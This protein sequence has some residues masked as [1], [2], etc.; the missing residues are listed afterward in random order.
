MSM[1]TSKHVYPQG[2]DSLNNLVKDLISEVGGAPVIPSRLTGNLW[3]IF[4]QMLTAASHAASHFLWIWWCL[5]L[6][7]RSS[8]LLPDVTN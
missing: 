8:A 4:T 2:L 7:Q 6:A 1:R 3:F 5:G